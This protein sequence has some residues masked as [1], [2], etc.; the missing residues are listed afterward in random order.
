MSLLDDA[1]FA[2][3]KISGRLPTPKGVALEVIKLTQ[4]SEISNQ[5]LVRLISSD[6]ALCTRVI[7]AAN[8]LLGN[9][10]RPIAGISDAV[11]VLGARQ[12]RQLVL[13]ISLM[14]DYHNGPCKQF[15]YKHF[16]IR[17]LLTG[18]AARHLAQHSRL[19]SAEESFI[20][21]LLS[22]I[23]RLAMA[24]VFPDEYGSMIEQNEDQPFEEL[25]RLQSQKFGFDECELSEAILA[26]MNF[27]KLFQILV[28][29]LEHPEGNKET[30]GSRN[31]RMAYLLNIAAF[32]A[33]V[34]IAEKGQRGALVSKLK[35]QATLVGIEESSLMVI[36]DTCRRDWLQ[37]SSTLGMGTLDIPPF[38]ELMQLADIADDT[39]PSKGDGSATQNE[40]KMSVLL[41]EDDRS[42]MTL[43]QSLLRS[44]GHTVYT[45]RN[46]V[47]ALAEV[48][49]HHPQLILSDWMMPQMD[50][51]T[52]C[53][54]LRER[55]D[56]RDIYMII[57]TAHEDINRLVEAFEAG[58][59]DY[60]VKPIIPKIFYARMRAGMRVAKLQ[61]ELAQEREQ[62]LHLSKDLATAN[63]H[64]HM[65]ALTDVLT[66]L[67]NRRAAMERLEQEWAIMMR[68]NRPLSCMM[69]DIDR[70]KLI[71]DRFGHPAGDVT[72]KH[73]AQN[74]RKSARAQ[75]VVC[76]IGG[77]EFLVI[78]PDTEAEEAIQCAERLRKNIESTEV[79]NGSNS[80][81][82]SI[83]IGVAVRT[84]DMQ[85]I[86][87]LLK[88]ADQN[89]YTAKQEGR[90]RTKFL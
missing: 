59:D 46:G 48:E 70:F 40:Y 80:L 22:K 25:H 8:A 31:W 24:T 68:G 37:W 88:R 55:E 74:L 43:M 12:L 1:K 29:N 14:H 65:L 53:R 49:L 4:Q 19:A 85:D 11:M 21:G 7:K 42:M 27:P 44:V 23:G 67:P 33:D 64:L 38:A 72:L 30:E 84:S 76:R 87:E 2:Q 69:L 34:C 3:L 58:A 39:G 63:E 52:F 82:V 90:N 35:R 62:L 32:I 73:V 81:K 61:H 57:M 20:V 13:G 45:A 56:W 78:C 16:W 6:P 75:D 18:I 15:N 9:T 71:N 83:S 89:L 79:P 5:E 17:S 26:D 66:A 86:D 50:G 10:S 60:L 54:K 41:V 36:G 51:I 77:E 47:E 28:R